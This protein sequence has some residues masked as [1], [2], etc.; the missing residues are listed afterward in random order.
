MQTLGIL[1]H[2]MKCDERKWMT[3]TR[4]EFIFDLVWAATQDT[5]RKEVPVVQCTVYTLP[6]SQRF[7]DIVN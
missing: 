1:L 3:S 6:L 2:K 5:R 4:N 7:T